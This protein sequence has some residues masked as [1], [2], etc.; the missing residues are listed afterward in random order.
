MAFVETFL[1][2]PSLRQCLLTSP[3]AVPF[4]PGWT[5]EDALEWVPTESKV[6]SRGHPWTSQTTELSSS[7]SVDSSSDARELRNFKKPA[8]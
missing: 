5:D 7:T 2:E 4:F 8:I 6:R 1:A 3:W